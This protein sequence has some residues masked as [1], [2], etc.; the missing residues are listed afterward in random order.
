MKKHITI[1][2]PVVFDSDG[3]QSGTVADIKI[4]VGN[5][6]R[7]ALVNVPGTLDGAPWQMPLDQLQRAA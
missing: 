5:G 6:Q 1:G 7:I 2:M 4:D 3:P